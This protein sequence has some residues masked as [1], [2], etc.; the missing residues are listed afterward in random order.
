[1]VSS[2][3]L[4]TRVFTSERRLRVDFAWVYNTRVSYTLFS[5]AVFTRSVPLTC[6][7]S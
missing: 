7:V 5:L 1:M 4:E 2:L 3:S 6:V